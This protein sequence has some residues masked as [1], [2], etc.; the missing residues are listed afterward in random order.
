[1]GILVLLTVISPYTTIIPVLY[2]TYMVLFKKIDIY[3]NHWNIG[4]CLLVIWVFSG[5]SYKL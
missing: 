2:M 4:L 1:M 5:W 3:I